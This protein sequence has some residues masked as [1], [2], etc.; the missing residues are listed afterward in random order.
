MDCHFLLQGIFLTQE[1]ELTG[2]FFTTEPPG[3]PK[4]HVASFVCL[5]KGN[6]L[7]LA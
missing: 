2:G 4:G 1:S 6:L 5:C 3:R 7:T